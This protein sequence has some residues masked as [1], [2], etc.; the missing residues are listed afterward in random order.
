[1]SDDTSAEPDGATRLRL[2]LVEDDPALT[3]LLQW[4]FAREDFDV[5]IPATARRRC[6]RRGRRRPTSSCSTG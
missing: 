3:D 2:L 5:A 6:A 1:M 4:H